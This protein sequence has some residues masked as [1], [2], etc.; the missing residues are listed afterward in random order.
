MDPRVTKLARLLVH[1][2]VKVQKGQLVR[3]QGDPVALPLIEEVYREVV[4][5]GAHPFT[6]IQPSSLQEIFLKKATDEQFNYISPIAHTIVNKI[7]CLIHIWADQNTRFLSGVDPERQGRAQKGR[8]P[9]SERLFKR[10]GKGEV[11]WVGTL[12]PTQA[13]AQDANM[14]LSDYREFVYRAGHLHAADPVK[15]WRSVE[16][17]QT[18]LKKILDRAERIHIQAADTDLKARVKGRKWISCHGTENFPDG[19]IFTSPLEESTEGV[20]R[21]SFPANYGGREVEDVRLE[22]KKGRVVSERAVRNIEFLQAMLNLDEGS[23]RVG[24][25]AIGTNYEIKQFTRNT[26]FDEKIGGTCHLAVGASFPEAGGKNKSSL[27]WD[28]V[29]DL[30]KDSQITADGKVI[31]R[32]GKFTI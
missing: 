28:M 8:R 22:F 25:I 17:E 23:R 30:K 10:I 29:C 32:N 14:S 12:F 21:F 27:H 5:A 6:D 19:E 11:K 31:Y 18:R 9:L 4:E 1:Y 15:H 7:D 13:N 24:E 26:L 16:K 20:I 2:S 3:I